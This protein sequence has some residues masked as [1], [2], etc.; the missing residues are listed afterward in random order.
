MGNG[1]RNRV[2]YARPHPLGHAG[3]GFRMLDQKGIGFRML[4]H[5]RWD[6]AYA[7]PHPLGPFAV[8]QHVLLMNLTDT[9]DRYQTVRHQA[10]FIIPL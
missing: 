4:D 6:R 1:R 3:I 8:R 9:Q 7:R 2:S 10:V 5:I